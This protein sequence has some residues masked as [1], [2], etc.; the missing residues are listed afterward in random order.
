MK[1]SSKIFLLGLLMHHTYTLIGYF[2]LVVI[3]DELPDTVEQINTILN[4]Y[5]SGID[6][7][8]IP[9]E[10]DINQNIVLD[11]IKNET[12][13]EQKEPLDEESNFP[14]GKHHHHS[15]QVI[16]IASIIKDSQTRIWKALRVKPDFDTSL[17]DTQSVLE[18]YAESKANFLILHIDLVG[19]TRLSLSLPIDR[20]TTIIRSF[21]QEMSRV[22]WMYGGY[23]L[24][25]VGD[26][27]LAFFVVE[28]G[29]MIDG[30]NYSNVDE[31]AKHAN[32]DFYSFQ[33][34]NVLA[35]AHTMI[36]VIQ[37]GINPILNQ[38][39]YPELQ[40]RMGMDFG[41]VAVVQYGIDIDE[42]EEK[43]IKIPHLDLI[44]YTVSI[45]VKMTSLAKPD[46][47]VIGQK[48]FDRLNAKHKDAFKQLP[49][50]PN[51]WNYTN[52]ATGKIY[53]LYGN[54]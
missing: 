41:E 44:G 38:Y 50:N 6:P 21:T 31:N 3:V 43:V 54:N 20:L 29:N 2:N 23:V 7:E 53:D 25:Y 46:H 37:E 24:K 48:L 45:A 28:D 5:N 36:K 17:K 27:V 13:K 18:R 42:F 30:G 9:L 40:V 15:H 47:M 49:E 26:A 34:G 14:L 12:K 10:L 8:I 19:S 1:I 52:E 11:V 39:D 33:Y 16:D 22:I 51:I 35:C 4:L 32:D